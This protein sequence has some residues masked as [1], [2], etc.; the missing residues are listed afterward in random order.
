MFTGRNPQNQRKCQVNNLLVRFWSEVNCGGDIVIEKLTY[1]LLALVIL[2]LITL[3]PSIA[4]SSAN[5]ACVCG[6]KKVLLVL[7]DYADYPHLSSQEDISTLVFYR[8]ARYFYDVSYGKLTIV[9]NSTDWIRLPRLYAQYVGPSLNARVLEIATDAFQA[10]S[11]SFNMSLFD[12]TFLVL[13]S[14]PSLTGDYVATG[15]PIVTHTGAIGDFGV[16]EEDRDFSAYLHGFAL[17]IGL[18]KYQ[19]ELSGLGSYDVSVTGRGDMSA[20]SKVALGWINSSQVVTVNFPAIR[21]IV[22]LAPIEAPTGEPLALKVDLGADSGQ[23]WVEVREPIGYDGNNLQEYGAVVSYLRSSNTSLDLLKVLQPD[24]VGKAVFVDPTQE[25]SIVVLNSTRGRYRLLVGDAQDGRDA[26]VA[27]YAIS[28][29]ADAVQT[30]VTQSRFQSLDL[31]E[32]LLL[33]AHALF[34]Q[35]EFTQADALA[36]SAETTADTATVPAD[37][38]QALQL[39]TTAE[40]LNNDTTGLTSTQSITL[41]IKAK[42]QLSLAQAALQSRNFTAAISAAQESIS[43]FN[44]AKQIDFTEKITTWVSD[45]AL[46]IPI[47][48]LAYALRYQLKSD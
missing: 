40:G 29:A 20:L 13:S 4:P 33:N 21:D 10:A 45:V 24:L 11:Q 37:Y 34:S 1:G 9:G 3:G 39:V 46:I 7:A 15:Q 27:L 35:G 5:S 6:T 31:A 43:L 14:Y 22:T 36:I 18:W 42:T 8:V 28:R 26:L 2:G 17:M 12:Y 23:Y 47:I 38:N 41:V 19:V 30:A 48:I 32:T 44:Q 16:V 25:V